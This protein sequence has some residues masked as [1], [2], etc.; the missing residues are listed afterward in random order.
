MTNAGVA[1]SAINGMGDN[2][3]DTYNWNLV[4]PAEF[5]GKLCHTYTGACKGTITDYTGL[6]G[7]FEEYSG[8]H[9]KPVSYKMKVDEE[10]E[11]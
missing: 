11:D 4:I 5:S 10:W 2:P 7:E 3:F 8:V 6:V 1:K 9:L